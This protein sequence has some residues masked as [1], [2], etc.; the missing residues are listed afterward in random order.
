MEHIYHKVISLP[1]KKI[2]EIYKNMQINH[3]VI[4]IIILSIFLI[5]GC[6]IKSPKF[7]KKEKQ[8]A[9]PMTN[10][11]Y[12]S[13]AFEKLN[14][15]LSTFHQNRYKFQVK[16]IENKSS[17]KS[18]P[19]D[20]ENFL[21]TPLLL[22]MHNIDLIAYTPVYN[23]RE[24]Q[25]AG[26]THFPKMAK[27]LPDL[28]INGAVT[29]F[30]KGIIN[31]SSNIDVDAQFGKAEGS[32]DMRMARDRSDDISQITLDLNVFKYDDR[33]FI[34][35][36]VTSNKIEIHRRR[37]RNRIGLF[38][39]GSGIGYSKYATLQQ[40]K[41]EALRIL[42]EYSLLQ[43]IGRLYNIPYWKC[44]TPNLEPD[45]YILKR[46]ENRF[47]N[48]DNKT[49]AKLIEELI[50]FF[51]KKVKPDNKLSKEEAKILN[52]IAIEYQFKN[53][54]LNAKF[55]REL[56]KVAPIFKD[57]NKTFLKENK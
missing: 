4:S 18:L 24:A 55:Y 51:G 32:T 48:A 38:V 11:T 53:R 28:V 39:N 30:D 3:R 35:G 2:M 25:I 27:Y 40:S 33:K 26:V 45:V 44:T 46:K 6:T 7:T 23:I 29:Q 50:P 56:Y 47:N 52:E 36:A 9:K 49:R 12:F 31:K 10:D 1:D 54:K 22:N 17:D 19:K 43:L 13:S 5:S 8:I 42:S 41:D 16:D 15:L 14:L 20:I 34:A 37:K 21:T 57:N